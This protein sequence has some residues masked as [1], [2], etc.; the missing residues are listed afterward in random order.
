MEKK[1]EIAYEKLC[2]TS[3]LAL[4]GSFRGI[5]NLV[6]EPSKDKEL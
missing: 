3:G 6:K 5:D 4:G 1:F 2:N